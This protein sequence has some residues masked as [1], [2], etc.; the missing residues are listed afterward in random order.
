MEGQ[1]E[2]R[3]GLK[4]KWRIECPGRV[5]II[6]EHIDYHGYSVLPM[7]VSVKTTMLVAPLPHS[8]IRFENMDASFVSHIESLPS[9]WEKQS[10]PLWFHYLLAGWKEIVNEFSLTQRG[11]AVLMD[12]SI[13]ASA[14]LS[15]SSSLVCA[16]ALATLTVETDGQPWNIIDKVR[17]AEVC[18]KAEHRVGTAGGGMDQA[19]EC[20]SQSG[21][22]LHISFGPLRCESVSLPSDCI[23]VVA[24]SKERKNKAASNEF[25]SRVVEGRIATALLAKSF[26][27]SNWTDM[28]TLRDVQE[29]NESS[30][31]FMIDQAKDL[32][33][34][35]SVE[36][37]KELLGDHWDNISTADTVQNS[38]FTIRP[39]AL[40]VYSEALRVNLFKAACQEG[41]TSEM[42]RLMT[43][44]HSSC[45]ESYE[46]STPSLDDLCSS[47][48]SA[49]ALGARLTGAGWGGCAVA[50]FTSTHH[51]ASGDSHN[52]LFHSKPSQGISVEEVK[53]L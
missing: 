51:F 4:P 52:I 1:F 21:S 26:G 18:M 5:N 37:V 10:K 19:A 13:P 33:E 48:L 3:F 25:N 2:S 17:L 8:Q 32:P 28:R 43:D 9:H 45:S 41:Q 20:L 38:S 27:L 47:L 23:F 7:A 16:A 15:S 29:A 40:H 31:Q 12:S 22:A 35:L 53:E 39:R 42:G 36:E 50:L 24:D 46:C 6:G 44:S 34:K 14:G 30:L 49:G 11:F